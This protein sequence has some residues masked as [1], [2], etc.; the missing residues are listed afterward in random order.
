[1][2]LL[3]T[4]TVSLDE[5]AEAVDLDLSPAD[6]VF[7]SFTDSDLAGLVTAWEADKA[8]LPSL[9]A[10]SLAQLKHP[11]SVDLLVEKLLPHAKFVLVRLLGGK[12]YWPYGVEEL[13][14]AARDHGFH[15]AIVPG[16][17]QADPRLDEASTLDA[18]TLKTLWRF[19]HEG[20]RVNLARALDHIAVSLGFDRTLAAPE[21]IEALSLYEAACRTKRDDSSHALI[22]AYRSVMIADDTAPLIALADAL[23]ERGFNVTCACV[24]S[25]KDPAAVSAVATLLDQEKPDIVLNTTAF[26]AKLDDGTSVLDRADVPVLQAILA[27]TR[28]E[29]WA[30]SSRGLSATDM[31]MNVVLPELDGRL[32]T[33]ALSF[34][35]EAGLHEDTGLTRIV[36]KPMPDRIAYVAELARRWTELRKKSRATRKLALILSDYPHKGGRA[37]Y[38]VGLDTPQSVAAIASDLKDAGY[39]IDAIPDPVNL[40][41]VLTDGAF[42]HRLSLDDY[43]T[44]F[45]SLP[46]SFRQQVIRQWGEAA[47]DPSLEDGGFA[48]RILETGNLAVAL[49]PPRGRSD[50]IK[51]SYHDGAQSP[52]HAYIAFYLWLTQRF[53]PDAMI[54]GG[55][56]GTLEWLPGKALALSDACAPEVL[57]GALPVI[58]PFIVN[59]PG[60]AAQA[61]RRLAAVTIGHLTPPL[62]EA[63]SHGA[64]I[65]LEGLIDEYATAETL[66][67]RRARK[68]ADLI[69]ERARSTG[70][71]TDAGIEESDDHS[72]VLAALDAWLCD[73]KEMRI[74]DGL[75]VFG[76]PDP[77]EAMAAMARMMEEVTGA[78][79]AR[80]RLDT[81]AKAECDG[82]LKALD[83]RFVKAGPAGAPSRGRMDVLPT[84]R[85]LYTIDPRGLPTRT[86]WEIGQKTAEEVV[87]RYLQDH[88][89]WPKSVVIDLWGSATMRTG[90][91][92][93][94]QALA[95]LG[96]R[97]VWDTTSSRVTGFEILPPAFFGRPRIDVTL[98]ISGLF[99]DVFPAQIALFDEAVQSVS[100][101]DETAEENPLAAKR[102]SHEAEPLRIFGHAPEQYGT[103]LGRILAEGQWQESA[104]LGEAYLASSAY[105]YRADGAGM[106]AEDAFRERVAEADA[107][108][109]VQDMEEQDI[110]DSDAFADHEGGFAAAAKSLGASP[111]LYHVDTT[112]A[113]KPATVRT[114]REEVARVLRAR[115][116][117]PRWIEGQMRHGYRGATEIAETVSNLFAY[118]AL[119][120]AVESRHFDLMFDATL[121]NEAVA[122]F[123]VSAN[124][125]AAQSMARTFNEAEQRGFWQSRRNS[126]RE[127]L[128]SLMNEAAE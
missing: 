59:N 18:D 43:E 94:A 125:A 55:T 67:P 9:T 78:S 46:D 51:S 52:S 64:A 76:R 87:T 7:L 28:E 20:G 62:T 90:G 33:R 63:G 81:S 47:K 61:K 101:L 11:F 110:L 107:F 53:K 57:I 50:D 93:L 89:D 92:D 1:M 71:L 105:A 29:A 15:L 91:D 98:R 39:T 118:A 117:N 10:A 102:S 123:L 119:A 14:R 38:A 49:Q 32:I 70:L 22:I 97:P 25:L 111:S 100:R 16:D 8:H 30:A 17:Y 73:I 128:Q 60:E 122:A 54:H 42:T 3:R 13:S 96:V 5:T 65:E 124:P 74:A 88:G 106:V 31:A 72:S 2:H 12:D 36:H 109:H 84:G 83:G 126:T 120:D 35:A 19:F 112:K 99:R 58:Y 4:E 37:G 86:A 127:T 77:T 116:T 68:L 114:V 48:W 113:G 108:I 121:G 80:E 82:L 75:H 85:N 115:A 23:Q 56:H 40:M 44:L 103:G 66:D 45:A 41:Q 21:S 26:S 6:I 104:E 27:T 24:S 34:K 69:L 79:D 95:L